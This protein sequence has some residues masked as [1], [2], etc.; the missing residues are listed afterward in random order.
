MGFWFGLGWVRVV[1]VWVWVWIILQA[2]L[3]DSAAG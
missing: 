1:W 3:T 2:A